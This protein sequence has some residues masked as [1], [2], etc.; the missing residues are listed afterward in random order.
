MHSAIAFSLS[1]LALA[2][3]AAPAR[4]NT[5]AVQV[6][7]ANDFSGANG[8]AFIPLNGFPVSLGQ[9]YANTNLSKDGTL[10]VT[11]LEFTANFANAECVVVQDGTTVVASIA[12][13][14]RDYQKFSSQPL[15]WENGVTISCIV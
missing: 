1:C 4:R 2:V 5:N 11:S 3:S 15:D 7:F 6:Q 13:P 8:N 14:E 12:N 9:A 10:F